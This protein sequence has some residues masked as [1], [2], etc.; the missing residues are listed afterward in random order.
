[1]EPKVEKVQSPTVESES[2]ETIESSFRK[3]LP[4]QLNI[5]EDTALILECEVND[6]KQIT[7]WYLDDKLIQDNEPHLEIINNGPIRQLKGL[8]Y[9]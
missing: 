5:D 8:L 2:E 3:P 7:D 1:M 6:G 9:F 4:G